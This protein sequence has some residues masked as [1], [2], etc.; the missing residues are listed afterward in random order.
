MFK[1]ETER[2]KKGRKCLLIIFWC[3]QTQLT[4]IM[5]SIKTLFLL[6][7]RI[8]KACVRKLI[9]LLPFSWKTA[10]SALCHKKCNKHFLLHPWVFQS[11]ENVFLQTSNQ[12]KQYS[13]FISLLLKYDW[14]RPSVTQFGGKRKWCEHTI[15]TELL[16]QASGR[17]DQWIHWY[18]II[19]PEIIILYSWIRL[20]MGCIKSTV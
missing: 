1:E 15:K 2:K 13:L 9:C 6:S 3:Y 4:E 10:A 19:S 20:Y 16:W 5:S 12:E 7:Q 14:F 17:S 11:C 18:V 8:Y